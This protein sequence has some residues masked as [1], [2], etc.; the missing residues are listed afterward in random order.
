M[1]D[2]EGFR[3]EVGRIAGLVHEIE[4]V[5]DPAL[6]ATAKELVQCVMD[7]HSV[8]IERIL[9]IVSK[10]G[11]AGEAIVKALGRDDLVSSLLVLYNLHPDDFDTRVNR[12]VEKARQ[13]LARRG[14]TVDVLAI[15][16]GVVRLE[17]K[18]VGHS[19]G[20]TANELQAII[21]ESLAET[22]PDAADIVI[23]SP[24]EQAA[25]GF[26]PLAKLQIPNGSRASA[27]LRQP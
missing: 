3:E 1:K 4:S 6:R 10:A 20:S 5:A 9:E 21:R 8:G 15:S 22:A 12:G 16:D 25:S 2:S 24:A 11:E 17:F 7:L 26:V 14:A 19:C 23:E 13:L 27:A 18:T